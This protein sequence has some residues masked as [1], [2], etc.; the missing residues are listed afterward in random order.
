MTIRCPPTSPLSGIPGTTRPVQ[1]P[2]AWHTNPP[3]D[4]SDPATKNGT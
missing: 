1:L 3:T 2:P 4:I